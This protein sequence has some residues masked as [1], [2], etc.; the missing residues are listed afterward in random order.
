M[1]VFLEL[2]SLENPSVPNLSPGVVELLVGFSSA[3]LDV[4]VAAREL[5]RHPVIAARLI[6]LSNSAWSSPDKPILTIREACVR[7]GLGVVKS[8]AIAYAV[9]EP[10]DNLH[11]PQFDTH[12]FW[13]CCLLT[14]EASEFLSA[15]EGGDTTLARTVGMLRNLGLIWLAS[16]AP[17]A[18]NEA[19]CRINADETVSTEQ[20]LI[21]TVGATHLQAAAHLFGVWGV[22]AD[23]TDLICSVGDIAPPRL[24]KLA[25]QVATDVFLGAEQSP[26]NGAASLFPAEVLVELKQTLHKI[27]PRV[28]VIAQSMVA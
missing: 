22:P 2:T 8:A 20:A 17:D 19:F 21:E 26:G 3:D 6:G 14:A 27:L 12:R 23:I 10:F 9:A 13:C 24:Y 16:A 5:E 18:T 4:D 28:E 25:S 1:S 15:Y 7:L 11:C